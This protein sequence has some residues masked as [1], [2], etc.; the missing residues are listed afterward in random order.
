MMVL[1]APCGP[2]SAA[3]VC[4]TQKQLRLFPLLLPFFLIAVPGSNQPS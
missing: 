1:P 2:V 3:G 4:Q